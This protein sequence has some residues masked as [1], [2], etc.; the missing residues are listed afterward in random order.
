MSA[1]LILS[2][3]KLDKIPRDHL[4]TF[5]ISVLSKT[6][7]QFLIAEVHCSLITN[8]LLFSS[9]SGLDITY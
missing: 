2:E 3:F 7:A 4:C 8:A 9:L 5:A 1:M 6:D